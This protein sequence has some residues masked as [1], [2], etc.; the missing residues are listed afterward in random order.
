MKNGRIR[1]ILMAHRGGKLEIVPRVPLNTREDLAIAY[2][3][4]VGEVCMAVHK[5]PS[6]A[7]RYTI[8]HNAVAIVTDG[9]AVL[10]LGD[11]GPLAALP[12]MEGKAILFKE[13]GGVDAYPVCLATRNVEKI[14]EIVCS[15]APGFGGINLEDIASPRCFII[16]EKLKR[17]LKIPVFHDDQHGTAIVV[18]AA[19]TNALKL[20]DKHIS[21]VRIVFNGAGAAGIAV[22]KILWKAGARHIF[23]CDR[24]GVI[25][26]KRKH[27]M[28]TAKRNIL[29]Y[30]DPAAKPGSLADAMKK[31]DVFIGLSGP[32][33]VT[34]EMVKSM[35][36]KPIIFAMANPVPEIMP[37]EARKAGAFIIGT[38]RSDFPNQIN[39][40]LAFP[41][42][43]RG[44]LDARA[45]Q[46]TEEMKV[47]AGMAIAGM[48]SENKLAPDYI[49]PSALDKAVAKNVANAVRRVALK[50]QK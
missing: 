32:K 41:G 6:D 2:T 49:I 46:I 44:A 23:L 47:A 38:G 50:N 39:N 15:M 22:A 10:G 11:I 28:N 18:L 34:R 1:K 12:V 14:V 4:G 43:F 20:A 48:V 7:Y 42:V 25:C 36:E 30:L 17:R 8:K 24:N 27:G 33:L 26:K 37:D 5:K 13:F 21:R 19:L 9:S 31:S 35:N 45:K 16:E 29:K 40:L 3:P